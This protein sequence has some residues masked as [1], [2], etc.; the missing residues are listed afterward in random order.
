MDLDFK[1]PSINSYLPFDVEKGLVDILLGGASLEECLVD[2]YI[3]NFFILPAGR[4]FENSSQLL[5]LLEM[6]KI[7]L[8]VEQEF[9][10]VIIDTPPVLPAADMNV[11]STLVDGI[12]FVVQCGNTSKNIVKKAFD[13][14]PSKKIL[15]VIL[16]EAEDRLVNDYL[17]P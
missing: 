15:G 4:P 12:F 17:Y 6:K 10:Y 1:N 2:L 16:N 13:S 8:K 5:S 3:E 9:D 14:L 11:L 7:L